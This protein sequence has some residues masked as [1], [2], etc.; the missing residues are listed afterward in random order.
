MLHLENSVF[1]HNLYSPLH[2]VFQARAPNEWYGKNH[3]AK[4]WAKTRPI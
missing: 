4:K 2:V 3:L 1:F